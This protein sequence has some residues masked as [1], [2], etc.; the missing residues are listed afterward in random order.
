M[1]EILAGRTG[2]LW[3]VI[4]KR[5]KT[6]LD[7]GKPC[8]L[9]VPELYTLQA[10]RDLIDGLN[11]PGL[12]KAQVF[13]PSR[14]KNRVFE[15]AGSDRKIFLDEQGQ[16]IAAAKAVE[17]CRKKLEFYKRAADKPGFIDAAAKWI[18]LIKEKDVS[19]EDLN[20]AA[21]KARKK[22]LS[23]KLEDLSLIYKEYESFIASHG[24]T[25]KHDSDKDMISRLY[26]SGIMRNAD[27]LVFG[28]DIITKPLID[29]L[30]PIAKEADSLLVTIVAD[31]AQADDGD[32]FLIPLKSAQNLAK[33]FKDNNVNADFS[34]YDKPL[35]APPDIRHLEKY[36]LSLKRKEY[37]KNPDS[38]CLYLGQT[39]YKEAEFTAYMAKKY[40]KEG[41]RPEDIIIICS[42]LNKYSAVLSHIL[43]SFGV[44]FYISEKTL[45]T[46]HDAVR[47]ILSAFDVITDGFRMEDIAAYVSTGY[48][49]LTQEEDW[50]IENYA[51]SYGINGSLWLNAFER[52]GEEQSA[53]A[54]ILRKK[55]I[56]PLKK[57]KESLS[58]AKN[59]QA[60]IE[61][62][63]SF[64]NEIS[65]PERL[66][67]QEQIMLDADFPAAADTARQ[68]YKKLTES[69][70][71]MEL[72]LK[73]EE[74]SLKGFIT[75]LRSS[76]ESCSLSSLPPKLGCVQVGELDKILPDSP[77][78]TFVMG[79]NDDALSDDETYIV[80]DADI[81]LIESA[82][83][84]DSGFIKEESDSLKLIS[85]Y[86]A[87]SSPKQKLFIS[88]ALS[89][90]TGEALEPLTQ[91]ASIKKKFPLLKEQGGVM[92]SIDAYP[93]NAAKQALKAMPQ[94]LRSGEL[95]GVWAEAVNFLRVDERYKLKTEQ[96][97]EHLLGK[98]P[99]EKLSAGR[100]ERLFSLSNMSV[101]RLQNFASCPFRHFV[102]EGLRPEEKKEWKIEP[103]DKGNFYHAA[104]EAFSKKAGGH[105]GYPNISKQ[106]NDCLMQQAAEEIISEAKDLPFSDT[107]RSKSRS[108][109]F[110]RDCKQ[111]AWTLTR[112]LQNSSFIIFKVELEFGKVGGILPVMIKLKD[113]SAIY[114]TGKIDRLDECRSAGKHYIRI[115]DYKTGDARLSPEDIYAGLKLQLLIYL[116]AVSG[117]KKSAPAGVFYQRV[118][119]SLIDET[120]NDL[121]EE[122]LQYEKDNK[123]S[124][125]G[126]ALNDRDVAYLMDS[127]DP[128]L[129]L[130]KLFNKD[131]SP[132]KGKMLASE[133][134]MRLLM[135][136]AVKK[137][138]EIAEE[139]K[140]GSIS[141]SP[142][143][144]KYGAGP[145]DYCD[146]SG[147]CRRDPAT[148]AKRVRIKE[149]MSFDELIKKIRRDMA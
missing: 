123:L 129:S 88:Y 38:I 67:E 25:D 132:S 108:R 22:S 58:S 117:E 103:S 133:E 27:C 7:K 37:N 97:I 39:P 98:K 122:K 109:A 42:D 2:R 147:I 84:R 41:V 105:S 135:D 115:I 114:L 110:I 93:P 20:A 91:I 138:G 11:L 107:D 141:A 134:E 50:R 10:E 15:L 80:S 87:L 65:L 104:L 28:F 106:E 64:L 29:I 51:E 31:K 96:V 18:A 54:E 21:E 101:S 127:G 113:G 19:Y 90:E 9:L 79:L 48:S 137:A 53:E 52:G 68:V 23:K 139:I 8:I 33:A 66:E 71:Q 89:K 78:I 55:L 49:G 120:E 24:F 86:K 145:C 72:M 3:E 92:S 144:N 81:R 94:K 83:G 63:I 45:F 13:S 40:L 128:P 75:L 124:M 57:L 100:A 99:A 102:S 121:D 14:L 26:C 1:A 77:E 59:I 130:G 61:A 76:F 44:P 12:L 17:S 112:G 116:K 5:V 149:T 46:S 148:N 95:D 143:V 118:V 70:D 85:L 32:A 142:A 43:S 74:M 56:T 82:M 131:G 119:S 125:N 62:E 60:F 4:L 126:I 35:Q 111:T 136:F 36:F 6:S 69:F 16:R 34:F 140:K 30:V 73:D 47:A 146:Y